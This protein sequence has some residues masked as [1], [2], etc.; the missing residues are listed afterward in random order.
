[1]EA[2]ASWLL[3]YGTYYVNRAATENFD[4]LYFVITIYIY[5]LAISPRVDRQSVVVYIGWSIDTPA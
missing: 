4:I 1:M 5:K 2:H 3:A